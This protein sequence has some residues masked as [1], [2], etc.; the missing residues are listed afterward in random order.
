MSVLRNVTTGEI[1]A[2]NV[3]RADGIVRRLLGLLNRARIE[4]SEGL[5]IA[6]CGAIHTIGMQQAIDVVFLDARDR[7]VRTLCA[8]PPNRLAV[9]CLR[10]RTTV[11]LGCG[12]LAQSDVLI[13]DE[14]RLDP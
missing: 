12:A 9:T 6:R 14:F 3:T 13:G 2:E 10:A 4:P 5:W 1:V 11:E 7:V 8:V